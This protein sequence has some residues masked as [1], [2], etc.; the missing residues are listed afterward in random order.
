MSSRVRWLVSFL[1]VESYVR[2]TACYLIEYTEDW[3]TERSYILEDKA[4]G[5]MERVYELLAAQAAN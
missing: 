3:E 2:L 5:S 4:L 1:S